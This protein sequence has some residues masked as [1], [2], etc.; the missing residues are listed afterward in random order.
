MNF[1]SKIMITYIYQVQIHKALEDGIPTFRSILSA[2]GKPTCILVTFCDKLLKPITTNKYTAKNSFSCGK[3]E[4]DLNLAI[5]NFDVKSLSPTFLLQKL[6]V[7]V[8]IIFMETKHILIVYEKV[9]FVAY[10]E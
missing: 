1:Q 4:F 6:L 7:F 5:T 2:L 8:P 9:L 3:E 10:S